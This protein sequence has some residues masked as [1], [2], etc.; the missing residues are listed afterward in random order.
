[1]DNK[2]HY[3]L[4]KSGKQWKTVAL[5]VAAVALGLTFS[6]V[7]ANADTTTT[8]TDAATSA[9]VTSTSSATS[10][11]SSVNSAA[12][13][14]VAAT[15]ASSTAT[16]ASSDV[17]S[18]SSDSNATF[19]SSSATLT[20]WQQS[21][22]G[23]WTYYN[24]NGSTTSGKDY[25]YLPT[26]GST[27]G[28]SY[29]W[30][31]T[32]NGNILSGIQEWAGSYWDFDSDDYLLHTTK[33]YIQSQWGDWYLVGDNGQILSGVQNWLG[34]YYYFDPSTYLKL[35]QKNY[36]QSQ[37]GDWYLVGDDGTVLSGVQSWAGT[38]YYFDTNTYLRVDNDYR[39]SQWGDW[40]LFGSDGRIL[41][42]LQNWMGSTYY[43]D[44]STYTKVTN[45]TFTVN[46]TEY[47]ADANGVVTE[48]I[49]AAEK[50]AKEWIAQRESGGSY[51]AQ[52]GSCYG[53]Y[54]LLISYLG[55]DLSA[56]NQERVADNYVKSRYGSWVAA[57]AFWQAHNWY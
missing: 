19:S 17:S 39:Q 7:T 56:A 30:Y 47:K 52:N 35:S 24:E 55:G 29:N 15:N 23:Q 42:G 48:T 20:G 32:D 57:K 38:Y 40:Y 34:T 44:P 49:S 16:S 51:T 13:S 45:T 50:E 36:V 3:K 4:Y 26:I 46:G 1:M 10:E 8:S 33:D 11:A 31:L 53:R 25:E 54:Q 12:T 28:K 6:N 9:A 43:F 14:D 22:D 18:T 41:S 27:D 2:K 5:S 21:T 37:W